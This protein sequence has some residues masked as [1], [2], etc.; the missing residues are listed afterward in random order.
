[1]PVLEGS[2]MDIDQ[3]RLQGLVSHE[4]FDGKQVGPVFIKVSS[5]G[6]P[7]RMAGEPV[8]PAEKFF[9]GTQMSCNVKGIDGTGRVRLF[10]EKP[11]AGTAACKPV[12]GEKIKSFF[13]KGLHSGRSGFWS[14]QHGSASF[15]AQYHSNGDYRLR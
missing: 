15:C 5:K 8:F 3:G 4:I 11:A 12:A 1:M 6:M 2:K 13:G 14:A 10:R 7:E 9:M